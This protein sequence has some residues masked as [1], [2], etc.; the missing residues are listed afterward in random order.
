METLH[1]K[2]SRIK[3]QTCLCMPWPQSASD[4]R[5]I[6]AS[7]HQLQADIKGKV[8]INDRWCVL[9]VGDTMHHPCMRCCTLPALFGCKLQARRERRLHQEVRWLYSSG[10]GPTVHQHRLH[11]FMSFL[12]SLHHRRTKS[13]LRHVAVCHPGPH[14]SSIAKASFIHA[15]LFVLPIQ[16]LEGL[17]KPMR[18]PDA[19]ACRHEVRGQS[20]SYSHSC[21]YA[22]PMSIGIHEQTP[23]SFLPSCSA[24]SEP[25]LWNSLLRGPSPV[26]SAAVPCC[27]VHAACEEDV[28]H[29][30]RC[31]VQLR[32]RVHP[33]GESGG[34]R[35]CSQSTVKVGCARK[36]TTHYAQRTIL[37][38]AHVASSVDWRELLQP[39]TFRMLP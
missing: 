36:S 24:P 12:Q 38:N 14:S 5:S 20:R 16:L 9:T 25:P 1:F 28:V 33:R 15:W 35:A 23:C 27:Y 37:V 2:P 8:V 13:V 6:S 32:L 22:C 19:L 17:P 26:A 39:R 21:L 3:C 4:V 29:A 18:P 11:A 30:L 7:L 10:S 31:A 34:M